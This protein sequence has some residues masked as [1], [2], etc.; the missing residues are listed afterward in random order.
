[1]AAMNNHPTIVDTLISKGAWIDAQAAQGW[2]ALTYASWKGNRD[3]VEMLLQRGADAHKKDKDGWTPLMYAF[4][5]DGTR[6]EQENL[7]RDIAAALG[8]DGEPLV[9]ASRGDYPGVTQAL[10][11]AQRTH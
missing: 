2:T 9:V 11:R 6:L 7:Q 5:R 10:S 1:M 3:V 8:I 4:W